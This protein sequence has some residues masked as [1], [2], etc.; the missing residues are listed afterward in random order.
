M[1]NGDTG[2]PSP[3]YLSFPFVFVL[4]TRHRVCCPLGTV[5]DRCPF[6]PSI[7][8]DQPNN[9]DH[10]AKLLL[11]LCCLSLQMS[12]DTNND[13]NYRPW[14]THGFNFLTAEDR[15]YTFVCRVWFFFSK[16]SI[17]WFW[18]HPMHLKTN[19]N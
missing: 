11:Q 13:A 16:L 18:R 5:K 12:Y 9:F 3:L 6:S 10:A 7:I 1:A 2:T 19:S 4:Y 15:L 8:Q 17:V 14:I